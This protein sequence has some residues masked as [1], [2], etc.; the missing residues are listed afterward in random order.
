VTGARLD[1]RIDTCE[2]ADSLSITT[3]RR[4]RTAKNDIN[5]RLRPSARIVLLLLVVAHVLALPLHVA[6]APLAPADH[7]E[8]SADC[9]MTGHSAEESGPTDSCECQGGSCC[10]GRTDQPNPVLGGEG[11]AA[12]ATRPAAAVATAIYRGELR[13]AFSTCRSRAPPEPRLS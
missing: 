10:I 9:P 4:I 8:A 3:M 5:G 13:Q 2:Y 11:F 6:A 7:A 1:L 12:I